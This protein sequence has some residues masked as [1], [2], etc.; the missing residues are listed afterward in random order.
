MKFIQLTIFN[1]QQQAVKVL[2][3]V[4]AI[5]YLAPQTLNNPVDIYFSAPSGPQTP[6]MS[7]IRVTEAYDEI[8]KMI[9]EATK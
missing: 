8:V 2:V 5:A 1:S 4:S 7:R 3:N 6:G 9:E